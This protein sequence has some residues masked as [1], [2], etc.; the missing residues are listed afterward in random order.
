MD[1]FALINAFFKSISPHRKDVILGIGDDGA[2]LEVPSG[3]TLVVSTDTLVSGVHFLSSWNPFDIAYRSIMVNVSDII[4][5]GAQPCW[6]SLALTLP[7]FDQSWLF[8]FAQGLKSA[9][10]VYDLALIGGDTTKG[11]LSITITVHGLVDRNHELRRSGAKA[12]DEIFLSGEIGA[13]ALAISLMDT[14]IPQKDRN[15]I[16]EKLL[17]PVPQLEF[18]N[19]LYPHATAAIDISDGLAADL[20]HICQASKVGALLDLSKIPVHP[21]VYKYKKESA[22]EFAMQGGDDYVLCFTVAE[23]AKVS[24]LQLIHQANLSCYAVGKIQEKLGLFGQYSK[25]KILP[26]VPIGY[27]HF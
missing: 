20:N 18:I 10:E 12:G 9:L 8:N 4:A 26:L 2:C 15:I 6:I 7:E 22:C 27:R 23:L 1:E 11:L 16:M 3:K 17:K 24:F 13:A 19:Y 5:M 14:P 25:N 21:L